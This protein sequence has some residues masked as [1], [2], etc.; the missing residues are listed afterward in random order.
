MT[1]LGFEVLSYLTEGKPST[2]AD[3]QKNQP[4]SPPA[5]GSIVHTL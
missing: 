3:L 1:G 5:V 2:F 4:L